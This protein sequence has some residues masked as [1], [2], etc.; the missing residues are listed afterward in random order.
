VAS[1]TKLVNRSGLG[2]FSGPGSQVADDLVSL[3]VDDEVDRVIV[4]VPGQALLDRGKQRIRPSVLPPFGSPSASALMAASTCPFSNC[5]VVDQRTST[6]IRALRPN[7]PAYP[8]ASRTPA[9]RT[10]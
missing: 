4:D 6:R 2:N 10:K 3:I 9:E 7:R 1:Y 5:S 8:K